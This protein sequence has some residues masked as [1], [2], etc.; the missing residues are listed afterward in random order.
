MRYKIRL[1]FIK[2]KVK[3]QYTRHLKKN[4][5]KNKENIFLNKL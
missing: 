3:Q 2:A 1:T 4:I 5:H